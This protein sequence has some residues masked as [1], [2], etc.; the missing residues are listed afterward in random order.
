MPTSLELSAGVTTWWASTSPC[1]QLLSGLVAFHCAISASEIFWPSARVLGA[2][3]DT[4]TVVL[5]SHSLT[6][7]LPE[8]GIAG[9][10][11]GAVL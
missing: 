5:S 8:A 11:C 4:C 2:S 3:F 9:D 10:C 7:L 1:I 6:V